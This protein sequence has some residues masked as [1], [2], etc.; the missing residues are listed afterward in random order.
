MVEQ[1]SV[2]L[3]N[4]FGSLADPVRRDILRRLINARYT[5]SQLAE[6][7]DIS[8]AAVAKHLTV[9]ERAKLIHKEQKGRE[10]FVS[11]SPE[12]VKDAT[13][14]LMQYEK[15]WEDRFSRVDTILKG[16]I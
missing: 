12:A 15:L 1:N 13:Y 16:D 6:Q 9:L 14:Y 7:Y 10:R 3:N 5:I 11:I 8:F 2:Y 4:L